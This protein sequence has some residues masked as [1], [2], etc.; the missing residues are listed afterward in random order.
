MSKENN[1][2]RG[3]EELKLKKRKLQSKEKKD[4]KKKLKE[5]KEVE[6][7]EIPELFF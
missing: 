5:S 6:T 3:R 7:E 1:S 4:I 2:K